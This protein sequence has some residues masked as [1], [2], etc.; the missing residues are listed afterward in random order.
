M[1]RASTPNHQVEETSTGVSHKKVLMWAFL[2]S[3]CLF[4][5]SLITTYV[6]Y[7]RNCAGAVCPVEVFDIPLTSYSAFLLLMSS[8][9]MVLGVWAAQR[10]NLKWMRIWL[11]AT[12]LLGIH[13]LANQGFEFNAFVHEGMTPRSSPAGSAFFTLTGLHG[14]HVTIGVFWLL[15]VVAWTFSKSFKRSDP[16]LNVEIAGLYWHFVDVVWIVIFTVVYL[17]GVITF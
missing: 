11:L 16:H 3:D 6:L 13:F 17:I 1:E 4:F 8:L 5:G 9:T 7:Q 14:T 12:A 10:R 2:A 15:S